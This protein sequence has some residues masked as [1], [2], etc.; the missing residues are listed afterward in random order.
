MNA[1]HKTV[2]TI[3][4]AGVSAIA[5]M[6]NA[7]QPN[8]RDSVYAVGT[9][10]STST[11]RSVDQVPG[12]QGGISLAAKL[13]VTARPTPSTAVVTTKFGRA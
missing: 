13:N 1:L 5:T 9:N 8:G 12:R 6:A 10:V 7:A 2:V 11:A 4:I 3:A